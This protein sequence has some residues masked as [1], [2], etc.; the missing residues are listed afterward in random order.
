MTHLP[1]IVFNN[2]VALIPELLFPLFLEPL[3]RHMS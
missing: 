3:T 1:A 2:I